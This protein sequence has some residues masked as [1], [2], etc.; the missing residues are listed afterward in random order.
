MQSVRSRRLD[1]LSDGVFHRTQVET[2]VGPVRNRRRIYR[3]EPRTSNETYRAGFAN[4]TGE[5]S[6]PGVMIS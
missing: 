5:Y 1:H 4:H 3:F 6:T 2:A